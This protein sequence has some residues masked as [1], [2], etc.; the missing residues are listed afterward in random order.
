MSFDR[1]LVVEARST[2]PRRAGEYC[3]SPTTLVE[4]S[5]EADLRRLCWGRW[6][7]VSVTEVGDFGGGLLL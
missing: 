6:S 7:F 4:L 1:R 2:V 3:L 5:G